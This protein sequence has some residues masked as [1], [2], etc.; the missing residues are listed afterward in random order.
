MSTRRLRAAVRDLSVSSKLAEIEREVAALSAE[1]LL[2]SIAAT[3]RLGALLSARNV[4]LAAQE[5]QL[6]PP[7]SSDLL[8]AKAA[9][10][11]L[12]LSRPTVYR[13]AACG[14]LPSVRL[15]DAVRFDP[16]D[17]TRFVTAKKA[18]P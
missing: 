18:R 15:G 12:G 11:R 2:D 9:A 8:D 13:L 16:Q 14:D 5:G 1:D 7:P 17:I 10:Q 3:A 6:T 4:A